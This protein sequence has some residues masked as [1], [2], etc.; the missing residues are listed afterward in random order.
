MPSLEYL[1]DNENFILCPFQSTDY[2]IKYS[3]E[4]GIETSRSELEQL[5]KG[6]YFYPIA[7]ARHPQNVFWFRDDHPHLLFKEGR[8]WEPS[9]RRFQP[10]ETF[11]DKKGQRQIG[12]FY[13]I[14]QIYPYYKLRRA[15]EQLQIK[16]EKLVSLNLSDLKMLLTRIYGNKDW[17]LD[18]HRGQ[19]Q[20]DFAASVCQVI[21]NRYF[22][23]T[24]SD[25]R[26]MRVTSSAFLEADDWDKYRRQWDAK[27]VLIDLG[28]DL[29]G[30]ERLC[31]ML[32]ADARDV[33]PLDRWHELIRFVSVDKKQQLKGHAQLALTFYA[34]SLMLGL[35]YKELTRKE[36]TL[37]GMT[38][39]DQ[40]YYYGAGVSKN[41]FEYLRYLANEF[42]LNPKPALILVVEGNGEYEQFP[43]DGQGFKYSGQ[44]GSG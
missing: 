41:P 43:R 17:I 30:V 13:S 28:L 18:S 35:F 42:H 40:E 22:P 9:A 6:G 27:S 32:E 38:S 36:V 12:S 10:W 39:G 29:P 21:S 2:F 16:P 33:D 44:A 14:F 19:T 11:R 5:E 31:H 3:K 34:M 1:I 23:Y 24:Q 26:T 20:A 37:R 8:I 25:R 4:R 15:I 7:R